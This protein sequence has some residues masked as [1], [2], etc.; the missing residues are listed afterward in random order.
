MQKKCLKLVAGAII[1]RN[2]TGGTSIQEERG[3]S[4]RYA[5]QGYAITSGRFLTVNRKGII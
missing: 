4:A 5:Y 3:S 1:R 2:S